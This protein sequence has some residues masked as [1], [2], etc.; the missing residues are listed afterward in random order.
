MI[1]YTHGDILKCE[2]EA[3]VN[4][5][6][7]VGVMGRGIAL[8][9]RKAHPANFEAYAAACKLE[10]VQPGRMFVFETGYL[11]PPRVI[12]NFPTKRHWRGKS[13]IEDIEAGLKALVET[14]S[15]YG[16]RSIAV[17]PLGSGLG[18]LDWDKEVRPLV[19]AA[20]RPLENVRVLVF[21]PKGAPASDTMQH[22][23][24]P[25]KMTAGRA[26][27][28]ELMHR[29]LGGLLDPFVTLLEVHK[30]MYFMQEAGEPLRLRYKQAPYGP[31]AENLRHVLN[32]IE[33]HLI[34]GYADGGDAPDK[35]LSLVPGAE[36]E[37][38]AFLGAHASTR[39]RFDRVSALVEGFETPFGLELLSTVHWVMKRERSGSLSDLV[40]STYAW[41]ERKRQFTPR[42]IG[43][44]AEVLATKGWVAEPSAMGR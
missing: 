38:S 10:E 8:Q 35:Q 4:T 12:I 33:G 17:P 27:L 39:E 1:E 5:V 26:A 21:E 43:I 32:E 29:Y 37:A 34:A 31:Y 23:R 9:F 3:L 11:T 25:P 41:N 20:L 15:A 22:R 24:E 6:N 42:Q 30:L 40:A 18:G 2:A 13:R 36:Q 16:I 44:A 14:I 28:V 19:D 7:C